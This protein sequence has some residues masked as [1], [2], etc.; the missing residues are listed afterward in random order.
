LCLAF[1]AAVFG[2]VLI[3]FIPRVMVRGASLTDSVG[4]VLMCWVFEFRKRKKVL[5]VFA[6]SLFG[7]C[8]A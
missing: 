5:D 6:R 4:G 2:P 3:E 1:F 8:G 7:L